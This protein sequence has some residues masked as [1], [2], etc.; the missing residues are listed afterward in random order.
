ME[1]KDSKDK[2]KDELPHESQIKEM[3][4]EEVE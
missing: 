1:S 4:I 3:Q 2:L